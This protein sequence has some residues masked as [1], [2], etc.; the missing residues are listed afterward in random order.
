M[1]T[2]ATA[3]TTDSG[4]TTCNRMSEE[5]S[6]MRFFFAL[7]FLGL[8]AHTAGTAHAQ[9]P[10]LGMG[11]LLNP[12]GSRLFP[13]TVVY[14]RHPGKPDPRWK[15]FDWHYR[16]FEHRHG[17]QAISWRLYFYDVGHGEPSYWT[18]EYAAPVIEAQVREL[19]NEFG[20]APERRFS[21][22]LFSS[23]GEFRQANLFFI[24]E[25]VQ[26]VTST[27]EPTMAIPYWGER[28]TF[29]H[30]SHHELVHQF[31]VQL[32]HQGQGM[33]A[34]GVPLWLIE[35]MAEY[36]SLRGLDTETL[37]L[38]RDL[39]FNA[40]KK[41]REALADYLNPGPYDFQHVYKLGQL[42]VAFLEESYGRGTVQ[43]LY[44]TSTVAMGTKA[45]PDFAAAL[46]K[47]SGSTINDLQKSWRD[48][49]STQ[50]KLGLTAN[51]GA[52]AVS[53]ASMKPI[54]SVGKTLDHYVLSPDG[55][56]VLWR[57]VDPLTG[58]ASL[59][60]GRMDE[61]SKTPSSV[62]VIHDRQTSA[63]SLY[64]L[65]VPSIAIGNTSLAFLA[66]TADGPELEL[67]SYRR[68]ARGSRIPGPGGRVRLHSF[69]LIQAHSPTLSPDERKVAFV[70]I[71]S[72]GWQ[73]VYLIDRDAPSGRLEPRALT[74]GAFSWKHLCWTRGGILGSSDR[75]SAG[76]LFGV[77]LLDPVTLEV[78]PLI[79]PG[80]GHENLLEPVARDPTREVFLRSTN[81]HGQQIYRWTPD[82][83]LRQLTF[84]RTL[85]TQPQISSSGLYA[86]GLEKSRFHLVRLPDSRD[87]RP[88]VDST[89]QT[90]WDATEVTPFS[91]R[92]VKRYRPFS[93]TGMRLEDI[94]AFFSSGAVLG[95][96]ATVSDLMRNQ[97]VSADFLAIN[98]QGV[99][100]ASAFYTS[101]EGRS[102]WTLGA[103]HQRTLRLSA[104]ADPQPT[105]LGTSLYR[106]DE[107]GVLGALQ[108][109]LGPYQ[110]GS[111]VLRI[112]RVQ[113]PGF[114]PEGP[115]LLVGPA[116]SYGVDLIEYELFSGPIR[117]FGLLAEA[118][119]EWLPTRGVASER[120]R[121]D[122]ARYLRL[123]GR[124]LLALQ[125]VAGASLQLTE[126][127]DLRNPFLVSSD[128]LFRA[129]PFNDDRLRGN[130]LV[131][132][133]SELRFPLGELIRFAPLRGIL[134]ADF[135]SIWGKNRIADGATASWSTGIA[136]NIPPV[137]FS[138][139]TSRPLRVADG[140]R[141]SSVFHFT[142]RYL[143]L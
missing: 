11:W 16:D 101:Q 48:Y 25:G 76:G 127:E 79:L 133:K 68:S 63:V 102:T 128:D 32:Q 53:L 83:G 52:K 54:R 37:A 85:M 122:V 47:T 29:R 8:A 93:G 118:A 110:Y 98:G 10:G 27:L 14:P 45:V 19:A 103:Y 75:G 31:Q 36:Y 134:A 126:G 51:G 42:K 41:R 121:L 84:V 39:Y 141:D 135:G 9:M 18:A 3:T 86:L 99:T 58:R 132:A 57:E 90:P 114:S 24:E 115:D 21:Y 71:N 43:K 62:E 97:I 34:M 82:Q 73:N 113:R 67:R 124:S 106:S 59:H 64:F 13:Q 116:V 28:E 15:V 111:G 139:L 123:W 74:Q 26:G 107:S 30:I 137:S 38:L 1:R 100:Q 140:P 5:A 96:G 87:R 49:L 138:F 142:L 108:Y 69:G 40:P 77:V 130:Y 61:R 91:P 131:G 143:Y 117:G 88:A 119:T 120:L 55:K 20:F 46:Q 81:G 136:F 89:S 4:A 6:G 70:G 78:K 125:A 2:A 105:A 50:M 80:L 65:Q 56:T 44:R 94:A 66:S 7:T 17:K 109:P 129:Y 112:G 22:L 23:Y 92:T 60:L 33:A 104:T 95:A 35:G 72:K 12:E